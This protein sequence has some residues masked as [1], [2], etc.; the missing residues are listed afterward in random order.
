M[1]SLFMEFIGFVVSRLITM[2]YDNGRGP[3]SI[4]RYCIRIYVDIQQRL[5]ILAQK[6]GIFF[7]FHAFINKI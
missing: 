1:Q 7:I 3:V 6:M 5:C 4:N 2:V